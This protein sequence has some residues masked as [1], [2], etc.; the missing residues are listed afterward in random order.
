MKE[1]KRLNILHWSGE[2]YTDEPSADLQTEH[3]ID[4]GGMAAVWGFKIFESLGAVATQ[5]TE[6]DMHQY[7]ALASVLGAGR[8]TDCMR[9]HY[10]FEGRELAVLYAALCNLQTQFID[11]SRMNM[12]KTLMRIALEAP[13]DTAAVNALR[14]SIKC[15]ASLM[16]IN[17]GQLMELVVGAMHDGQRILLTVA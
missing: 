6:Q 2:A 15:Q 16:V 13:E 8:V 12:E 3:A 11:K 1:A 7:R 14:C 9:R 4:E 5:A 10:W 17:C